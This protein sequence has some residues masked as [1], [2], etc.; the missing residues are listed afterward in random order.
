MT[1]TKEL[2]VED[3]KKM[4]EEKACPVQK[5]LYYITGFLAGPMCGKCFPC[6]MGSYEAGIRLQN[7]IEGKGKEEDLE[8]LRRIANEMF[9]SSRCKMGKDT[10]RF[11]IEWMGTNL[12]EGHIKGRCPDKE[13]LALIEYRIIPEACIMCGLCLDVCKD[14][15]ILGEKKKPY[16][17]NYLPYEIRQKR[18]TKCGECIKVCPTKAIEIVDIKAEAKVKV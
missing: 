5:A 7:I 16:K 11:I 14:N 4:A 3:I 13:C 8:A 6:E 10:A 15:A 2:K 9:E 12:Y 18:C 17:A 1:E